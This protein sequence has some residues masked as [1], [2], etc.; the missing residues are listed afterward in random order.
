MTADILTDGGHPH[1][2]I[3]GYRGGCKS[4][5]CPAPVSCRTVHARYQGDYAFRKAIDAGESP[6]EFVARERVTPPQSPR[7]VVAGKRSR[8]RQYTRRVPGTA[9]TPNQRAIKELL[10]QGFTDGEIAEKLG[11]TRDQ[12]CSSRHFMKLPAN[13]KAPASTGAS[14]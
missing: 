1:G 12:V 3:Q 6:V 4:G 14:S 10:E 13:R 2:T 8:N 7:P 11:K 5:A 9:N